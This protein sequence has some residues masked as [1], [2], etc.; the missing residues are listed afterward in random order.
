MIHPPMP[1]LPAA[2]AALDELL[3]G[4]ERFRAGNSQTHIYTLDEIRHIAREQHP[5]AA[6]IGCMDSRVT[7]EIIFDQAL[8]NI[9]TSRVP[10]NVA[11]D[12]AKWMLEIAVGELHVPLVVVIGHTGCLA[13]GQLLD[14][15]KGGPGG[16][17]RQEINFAVFE[18]RSKN[19]D[20]LYREAVIQNARL[21]VQKLLR[22]S[23]TVANAVQEGRA[24]IVSALYEMETG[25]VHLV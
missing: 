19:P 4:N 8:G 25:E 6:V 20:D 2:R 24:E 17:L 21:T 3:A 5:I 14:G 11:S 10:G 13:V 7:P 9:F 23:S 15:D 22:D 18:A 16:P 12:S 1:T